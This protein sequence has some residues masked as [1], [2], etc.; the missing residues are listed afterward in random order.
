VLSS[1][2]VKPIHLLF[3]LVPAALAPACT[4]IDVTGRPTPTL[5]PEC[6][7]FEDENGD[8]VTLRVRNETGIDFY[9]GDL[10][11]AIDYRVESTD[12]SDG[13][14]Y[15]R[16]D[17]SCLWTCEDVQTEEE[18]VCAGGACQLTSVRVP[19]FTSVD[20]PWNGTGIENGVDMPSSCWFDAPQGDPECTRI[21]AA[22]PGT[23]QVAITAWAL[24]D[25]GSG[26]CE[27]EGNTCF[28]QAT[29]ASAQPAPATL[30][31]PGPA[32]FEVVFETCAFGCPGG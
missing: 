12:P 5:D 25:D 19:A 27:C 32:V 7:G 20:I 17:H 10:C 3:L 22:P 2:A 28:G 8:A 18:A 9:L 13:R 30:T 24:C 15:G 4:V 26:S 31:V 23:Y 14:Y 6:Q 11:G 21:V 16:I 1:S 29:G